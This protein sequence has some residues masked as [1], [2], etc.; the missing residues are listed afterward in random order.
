MAD[1]DSSAF[2]LM[3]DIPD[4]SGFVR[5][6]MFLL[7]FGAWEFSRLSTADM[8][9]VLAVAQ[10]LKRHQTRPEMWES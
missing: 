6:A 10:Y 3:R 2:P 5:H 8:K 7:G 4:D 1:S 9:D